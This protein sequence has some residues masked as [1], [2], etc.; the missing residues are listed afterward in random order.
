MSQATKATIGPPSRT[1]EPTDPFDRL[2]ARLPEAVRASLSEAQSAALKAALPVSDHLL[3]TRLSV[4][5]LRRRYYVRVLIGHE[6]RS[7]DRLARERQINLVPSLVLIASATWVIVSAAIILG[8]AVVYLVKSAFGFDVLDGESFL[9]A[10][11]F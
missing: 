11:F 5:W 1:L 3:D 6:R 10:C 7:L 2:L 4:R 8:I 9:H